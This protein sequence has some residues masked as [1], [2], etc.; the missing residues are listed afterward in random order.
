MRVAGVEIRGHPGIGD[1]NVDLRQADSQAAQLVVLAGENG[2]GKT[3]VMEA[4][5][6]ALAPPALL[7][8]TPARLAPGHYRILLE[9]DAPNTSQAFNLP[10]GPEIF[11]EVRQRWP[12]FAGIAIDVQRIAESSARSDG[13]LWFFHRYHRIADNMSTAGAHSSEDILGTGMACFYSEA[14]VSFEVPKVETIRTLASTGPQPNAPAQVTFPV[15]SGALLGGE[16][17]QLLVDLQRADDADVRRWLDQ[18]SEGRPP[19]TVRNRR[20][21]R[22]TEAFSRIAPHKRY[23]GVETVAGEHRAM[24]NENG[25][26]TALSDLSTGEKQIVFRGAFLLRQADAL[27]GAVVLIDEP[28]L[29]LHPRWQADVLAY[30]DQIVREEPGRSSQ[31]IVATHSPFVVHGSPNAKHVVLRRERDARKVMVDP[32]PAYPGATTA[33]MAVAAFDL[34]AF[35]RDAQGKRLALVVEG[36]TDK[37]IIEAAWAALRPGRRIPFAVLPAGGAKGVQ[38]L[39]GSSEPG[40]AG[41]L[42]GA[43]AAVG[44]DRVVGLFDFDGEGYGQWNG[45]I[46]EAHAD[47][48]A[49]DPARCAWRKRRSAAVWAALL[50]VPSY[51]TGYAGFGPG[52]EGRSLLTIEILFPDAYVASM[53]T[54]QPTVGAPGAT[55]L[56]PTDRQ[57]VKVAEAARS[58]LPDAFATFEP[59]FALLDQVLVI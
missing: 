19:D 14:N 9:L 45:T 49:R 15:R 23:E 6:A 7:G 55:V 44:I 31:V 2:S 50:P 58:F 33:E 24:F 11:D 17:A 4:I 57:K 43:L 39:L 12:G 8:S 42:L 54:L 56:Q 51:R 10:S 53:L 47:G 20:V 21:W 27:P 26:R 36:P 22:F 32:N 38:Q 37:A 59:I 30:Y 46:K 25:F 16:V 28:E 1:L 52:F 34:G 5:F 29:S 18:H 13:V 3:A 35:A 40:K 41:P 48:G